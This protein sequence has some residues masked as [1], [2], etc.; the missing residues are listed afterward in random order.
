MT[1]NDVMVAM[2]SWWQRRHGGNDVMVATTGLGQTRPLARQAIAFGMIDSA[3]AVA[4]G[5]PL[6]A[7]RRPS[8]RGRPVGVGA[9]DVSAAQRRA[10][11]ACFPNHGALHS[12]VE[13]AVGCRYRGRDDVT[14]MQIVGVAFLVR[15]E[16][17]PF[18][19]A[20]Q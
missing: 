8:H 17:L 12:Q 14:R 3:P 13:R 2:T 4:A 1:G 9:R 11:G 10:H 20:R 6:I 18:Q 16:D 5:L 7:R 19:P 15:D